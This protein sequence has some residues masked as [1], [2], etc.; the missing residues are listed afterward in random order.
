[1]KILVPVDGSASS[2]RALAYVT[3]HSTMFA[4]EIS[5][6]HVHLPCLLAKGRVAGPRH[7]TGLLRRRIGCCIE[8][9]AGSIVQGGCQGRVIKHV[10]DPGA[11]SPAL[12]RRASI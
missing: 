5:L 6:M 7:R 1:M 10:G 3:S 11:K 2:L 4:P 9:R 12:Q 8:A